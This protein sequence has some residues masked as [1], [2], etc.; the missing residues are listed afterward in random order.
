[1]P[2]HDDISRIFNKFAG[3]EIEMVES[4]RSV[5]I[6]GK[7]QTRTMARLADPQNPIIAEMREAAAEA[8]LRLRLWLPGSAGTR[9]FRYDRVNAHVEKNSDGKYRVANRFSIG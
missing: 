6:G 9:D 7:D 5:K 2:S 4:S 3:K 8:G 1:M